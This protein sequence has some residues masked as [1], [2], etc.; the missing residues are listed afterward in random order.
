MGADNLFGLG[1]TDLA[2]TKV[3]HA[4]PLAQERVSQNGQGSNGLR[5]VH[6]HERAHAAALDF[7]GV[8]V[9]SDGEVVAT[10]LKSEVR[11]RRALLTVNVV[12]AHKVLGSTNLLVAIHK[13]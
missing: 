9:G 7:Q 2:V 1:K 3:I 10:Q 12:L 8:V 6:T 13:G 4:V 11:K 5:E